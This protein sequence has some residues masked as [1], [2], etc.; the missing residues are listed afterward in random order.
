MIGIEEALVPLEKNGFSVIDVTPEK[1]TVALFVWRP[2]KAA[3]I[4][5]LALIQVY[6]VPA[7]GS[8]QSRGWLADGA[9][10]EDASLPLIWLFQ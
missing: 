6:E 4:D 3:A 7:G 9:K 5:S 8:G 1:L 10:R 2:P